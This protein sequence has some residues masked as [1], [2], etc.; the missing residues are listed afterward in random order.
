MTTNLKYSPFDFTTDIFSGKKDIVRNSPNPAMA[1][2]FYIPYL[3]NKALSF[4]LD[5]CIYAAEMDQYPNTDKLVQYDYLLN[6]VRQ[7][8][9]DF[10]WL[11]SGKNTDLEVISKHYQVNLTKASEIREILSED[12]LNK[13][14][15][16]SGVNNNDNN[17]DSQ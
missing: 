5:T 11:K 3:A 7:K 15:N 17:E 10:F 8:K 4:H 12:D 16:H 1:E 9:R 14:I 6:T 2:K 13:I